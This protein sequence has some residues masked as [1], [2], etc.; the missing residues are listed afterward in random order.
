MPEAAFVDCHSHVVPSGD[1][2][3]GSVAEGG[4]LC[5]EAARRGTRILWATPHVSPF[6]PLTPEREREVRDAHVRLRPRAGLELRLGWELT[7]MRS[8]LDEDPRRFAL[9]GLEAVLVEV[10]FTGPPELFFEVAEWIELA[11]L[12]PVVAH[13]ERTEAGPGIA[14]ELAR[15]GWLLQ[16]NA[17]SLTGRHGPEIEALGWGLLQDGLAR[18]VASDGHRAARP[19]YVDG[20]YAAARERL[21]DA[22]D[23]LFDGTAL[24]LPERAEGMAAGRRDG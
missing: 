22:A 21:G 11:G 7:P 23:S 12:L 6:A 13:P 19:P 15:R 17:T 8:L 2:G 16:V 5:R 3:V 20:A 10:P 18:I 1:D 9:E 14:A 24:G 4:E